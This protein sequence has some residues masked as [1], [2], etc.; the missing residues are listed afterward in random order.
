MGLYGGAKHLEER[1][2]DFDGEIIDEDEADAH[3]GGEQ[4]E[5]G[6]T[7][8]IEVKIISGTKDYAAA[9]ES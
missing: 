4:E 2:V 6:D 1:T 8:Q 3:D 7:N 9:N 5:L